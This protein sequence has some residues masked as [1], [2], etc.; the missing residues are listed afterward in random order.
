MTHAKVTKRRKEQQETCWKMF[1]FN[2]SKLE[3][4]SINL[5]KG[6]YTYVK[7]SY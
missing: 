1:N 7:Y 3:C 6:I 5:I 4:S 2:K